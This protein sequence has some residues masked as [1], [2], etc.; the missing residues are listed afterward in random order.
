M[1]GAVT[2]NKGDAVTCTV[3]EI[4]SN[5]ISVSFGDGMTGFIKKGDLARERADQKPDRFSIGD[6][7]DA[8]VTAVDADARKITLSVKALEIA[9]EKEAMAQFGASDSGASLGDILGAAIKARGEAPADEP[10][11][12]AAKPAR[13][14]AAKK[15]AE[16][17]GDDDS[18]D[19]PGTG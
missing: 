15:A 18:A 13:K 10:D 5:G 8:R 7:V 12:D 17:G 16:T 3:T 11:A 1:A 9:Y 6:K 4:K 2:P 14:P 19:E